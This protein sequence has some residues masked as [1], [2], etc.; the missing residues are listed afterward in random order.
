MASLLSRLLSAIRPTPAALT[1]R[2]DEGPD[3]YVG[4][5]AS[6]YPTPPEDDLGQYM[7]TMAEFPWVW[8]CVDAISADLAGLPVYCVGADGKQVPHPAFTRLLDQPSPT[9]RM[10][11]ALFK[12]QVV[13]DFVLAR[14]ASI[15]LDQPRSPR[16]IRRIHPDAIETHLDTMGLPVAYTVGT[17]VL[18]RV[19]LDRIVQVRGINWHSTAAGEAYGTSPIRSLVRLLSVEQSVMRG[20]ERGAKLTR[21]DAVLSPPEGQTWTVDQHKRIT[22]WVREWLTSKGGMLVLPDQSK[23]TALGFAPKDMEYIQALAR[24]TSATLAVFR[25]PPTKVGIQAANYATAQIEDL[26]YWQARQADAVMLQDALTD[27]AR[28]FPGFE[29]VEV[30]LDFSGVDALQAARGARLSRVGQHILN[31]MDTADA[32]EVE[33]MD[34]EAAKMRAIPTPA[35]V[36]PPAEEPDRAA[37]HIRAAIEALSAVGDDGLSRDVAADVL[38]TLRRAAALRVAS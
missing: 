35:P 28:R 6:G 4:A 22:N 15:W 12:R 9:N 11:G 8:A 16:A 26:A 7:A 38:V 19:S 29:A 36:A 37:R 21:P 23:L 14:N 10:P 31:G 32:Y 25:V 3:L 24:V 5:V 13:A 34:E 1:T 30:R 2:G 27:I 20:M 33:G 18:E 17:S